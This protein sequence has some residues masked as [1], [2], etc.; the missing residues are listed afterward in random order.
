MKKF[1]V[2]LFTVAALCVAVFGTA[3]AQ[4]VGWK[5][6]QLRFFTSKAASVNQGSNDSTVASLGAATTADTTYAFGP[7]VANGQPGAMSG[8]TSSTC[9]SIGFHVP[10]AMASGESVYV[11]IQGSAD[12]LG[13]WFNIRGGTIPIGF[14][15]GGAVNGISWRLLPFANS[16]TSTTG[17]DPLISLAYYAG[18]GGWPYLRVILQQD[19]NGGHVQQYYGLTATFQT[20]VNR[21]PN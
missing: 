20:V 6:Q 17:L 14:Q 5:T 21:G 4:V 9:I 15:Q 1:L 13:G 16:T 2:A 18:W 7:I 12:G 19:R 8:D 10:A 11:A 3:S